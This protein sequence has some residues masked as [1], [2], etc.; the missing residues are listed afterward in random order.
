MLLIIK[1]GQ[2]LPRP[3]EHTMT[4]SRFR[5]RAWCS[6]VL[7]LAMQANAHAANAGLPRQDLCKDA[8]P[9]AAKAF[10]GVLEP[11]RSTGFC[12]TGDFN[13]DGKPDALMVV[14][15]L[16]ATAPASAKLRAIYPFGAKSADK[17]R[18]QFLALHST[19]G[20]VAGD[21]AGYDKL[22]LDGDSPVM[23]LRHAE[24][25]SDMEVV[26]QR[27]KEIKELQVPRRQMR[28]EAVSL[29]MEAVPAILYWNGRTYVLHEDPSGP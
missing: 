5:L 10:A 19:P 23:V 28:G 8:V 24:M 7:A 12:V 15:V 18:R 6:L 20:S 4:T 21:L 29:G 14:K 25:A 2:R 11:V 16:V 22:L 1:T 13:G 17:G 27:S 9:L 3:H 26:T